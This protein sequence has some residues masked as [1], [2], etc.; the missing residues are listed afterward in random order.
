[1]ELC[2]GNDPETVNF[3]FGVIHY[4]K[5]Y[6]K[7]SQDDAV[8]FINQYYSKFCN[9]EFTKD[10]PFPSECIELLQHWGYPCVALRVYYY[11]VLD[12]ESDETSFISWL[13]DWLEN[14]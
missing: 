12:N 11:E 6:F 5:S 1:M 14:N 8:K 9:E 2:V 7:Y 10:Y 13:N 4:F 3:F